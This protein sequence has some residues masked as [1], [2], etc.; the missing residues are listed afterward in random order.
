M[1]WLILVFTIGTLI[2]NIRFF[3]KWIKTPSLQWPPTLYVM[4]AFAVCGSFLAFGITGWL[5]AI[6]V[7]IFGIGWSIIGRHEINRL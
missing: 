2:L 6:P 3:S 7:L 5:Y 1:E 4:L